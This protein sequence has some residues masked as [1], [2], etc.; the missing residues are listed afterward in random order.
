MSGAQCNCPLTY[1]LADLPR[2][3]GKF[4]YR[5][6][7]D[8]MSPGHPYFSYN[9]GTNCRWEVVVEKGQ[10]IRFTLQILDIANLIDGKCMKEKL[11]I[12]GLMQ[13]EPSKVLCGQHQP[14]AFTSAGP[15]AEVLFT[16]ANSFLTP[17]ERGFWLR[18][19]GE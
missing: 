17:T 7:G 4:L 14:Q 2:C 5:K 8:I 15:K 12:R 1:L 13:P 6:G 16:T 9:P 18:F 19:R 10:R 11:E 3:T